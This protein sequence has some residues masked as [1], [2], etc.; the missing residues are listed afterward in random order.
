LTRTLPTQIPSILIPEVYD[1]DKQGNEVCIG[2][3]K[4]SVQGTPNMSK[5][6]TSYVERSNLTVR[7]TNRRF[8]RLTN[9][10]SKKIDN[11]CHMLAVCFMNYNFCRKHSTLKK[12]P[13]QEAMIATKQWTL[14]D[15][16]VMIEQYQKAKTEAAFEAAF[17]AK[18]T[19]T[20][21]S[22]D[23]YEPQ[24][25][26]TPWYLDPTSGGP[27]PAVKKPGIQ[28]AESP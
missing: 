20:T 12:T 19:K 2:A 24:T 28:Y 3:K 22:S 17:E 27:N 16:V 8:T 25:P 11:H 26:K 1:E 15:V 14:D 7:M 6:S 18:L 5:V 23:T 4:V 10:F 21:N 13:A 9:G